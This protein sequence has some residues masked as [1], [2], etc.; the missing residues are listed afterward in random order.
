MTEFSAIVLAAVFFLPAAIPLAFAWFVWFG[1]R[2]PEMA[3]WRTNSF[4]CGLALG[5]L[6]MCL[7]MPSCAHMAVTGE[8]ARGIWL[9]VNW[10]GLV[11]W[12]FGFA[13]AFCGRGL[14]RILLLAWGVLAPLGMLG[15]YSLTIP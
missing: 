13:A 2:R 15:A 9:V 14:G 7:V 4:R 1:N 6:T 12:I 11:S 10:V 5:L 8:P 3:K